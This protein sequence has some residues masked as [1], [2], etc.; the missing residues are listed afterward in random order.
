MSK[1][2]TTLGHMTIYRYQPN[3]S[4]ST[5][6]AIWALAMDGLRD[7][8]PGAG[9]PCTC[10]SRRLTDVDKKRRNEMLGLGLLGTII[11]ICL[12]VWLVRKVV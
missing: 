6:P 8:R 4:H 11:V 12:V 9:R 1:P 10:F 7:F 5:V 2:V 3:A